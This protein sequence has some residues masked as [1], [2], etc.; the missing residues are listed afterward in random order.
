M[1]KLQFEDVY[2]PVGSCSSCGNDF[3]IE[4][5]GDS[6][7]E[8][9]VKCWACSCT[10]KFDLDFLEE[11]AKN[12]I[13]YVQTWR[14]RRAS[15]HFPDGLVVFGNNLFTT[16]DKIAALVKTIRN[17]DISEDDRVKLNSLL[18]E[19]RDREEAIEFYF[20]CHD[21]VKAYHYAANRHDC[22]IKNGFSELECREMVNWVASDPNVLLGNHW[23]IY[24]IIV[25]AWKMCCAAIGLGEVDVRN[26]TEIRSLFVERFRSL[27]QDQYEVWFGQDREIYVNGKRFKP[28]AQ[29]PALVVI[30]IKAFF[31]DQKYSCSQASLLITNDLKKLKKYKGKFRVGFF[32]C[33]SQKF[34]KEEL[35]AGIQ[36]SFDYPVRVLVYGS[37]IPP[38]KPEA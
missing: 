37:Q 20:R 34:S 3:L 23:N 15:L 10:R 12:R 33:F 1:I 16:T 21:I 17:S 27:D 4:P 5:C 31:D 36:L 18:A 30:E 2:S 14:I 22:I 6:L 26:E 28:D 38:A 13:P 29:I 9:E 32:L 11:Y 19:I 8:F 25:Q 7:R 35:M 24:G